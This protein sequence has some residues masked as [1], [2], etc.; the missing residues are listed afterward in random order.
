MLCRIVFLTGLFAVATATAV[1]GEPPPATVDL[2]PEFQKFGLTALA[3]GDRGDCSLFA[4]TALAEIEL[5]RNAPD[6]VHRLS[7]EFLIWAAHAA[8]ATEASDQAM[9]YQALHGLNAE[10][11]CISKL[12]PYARKHDG[13]HKPSKEAL[14]DARTRS[15]RWKIHWIKRWDAGTGLHPGELT[16]IKQ[17]LTHG[18]PVACGLRWPKKLDG[19]ELLHVLPA[20]E[21][22][23]GHSIA[24]TG[25][26]DDTKDPGGGILYFKNSFGPRWGNQGYGVMS[27]AYATAYANDAVWIQLGSPHSE[28]P[29]VRFEA[30]SLPILARS[31][32]DCSRQE[33]KGWGR[34]MWS[35]GEQLFCGA[36]N[37]GSVTLGFKV[38]RPGKYRVRVLATAA[39]D[40]GKIH[41]ALDGRPA[42]STFDLYCGRVSP[43]GS[44]ELGTHQLAAGEH[45]IRIAVTGKNAASTGHSFGI[46]AID[47]LD[48]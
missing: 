40:F 42:G 12:M 21:V 27:Y 30:E 6:D 8:S 19:H 29:L 14:A 10:G 18:H 5:A 43:S 13:G 24:F 9:F 41:V 22:E 17:A 34:G 39:P 20:G 32:C 28:K 23:D 33:M 35:H 15:E 47:L 16:E 26:R 46:D 1:R 7:E 44:L 37:G 11:I 36:R 48:D 3:Q 31:Q 4:V 45:E 25:Y 2:G 38:D